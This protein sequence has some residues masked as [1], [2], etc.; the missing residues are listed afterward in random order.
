MRKSLTILTIA[1][2]IVI[3]IAVPFIDPN[4]AQA[5]TNTTVT[6]LTGSVNGPPNAVNI[7]G[8]TSTT[9]FCAGCVVYI[10]REAMRIDPAWVSGQPVKVQRG[11]MSTR[12][13]S[14]VTGSAVYVGTASV[15]IVQDPAG[16]CTAA[17]VSFQPLINV[18]NGNLWTCDATE[19]RWQYANFM[20]S[21]MAMRRTAVVDAAFTATLDDIGIIA[22]SSITTGRTITLPAIT[23]L[24]GI[25]FI[26]KNETLT[27]A[28]VTITGVNGQNFQASS[29][30][31]NATMTGAG[32]ALRIYAANDQWHT[33]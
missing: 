26:I 27:A 7:I 18:T 10:D 6:T 3:G 31:T 2:L 14:H 4:T 23:N 17:N 33:W 8:V 12:A 28:T 29:S 1:L 13:T 19:G 21:S 32:G 30:L 25:W 5:Q 20:Q 22:F 24:D 16:S 15:F 11:W 9:T